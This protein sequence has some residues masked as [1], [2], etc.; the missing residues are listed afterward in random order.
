M[1]G[2]SGDGTKKMCGWRREGREGRAR[3]RREAVKR[4]GRQERRERR[5]G[6]GRFLVFLKTNQATS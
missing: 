2:Q 6:E 3:G 5:G 4:R 1:V